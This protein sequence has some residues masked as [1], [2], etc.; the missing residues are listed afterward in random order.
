MNRAALFATIFAVLWLITSAVLLAG[1]LDPP[2]G[3]VAPAYKTLSEVEP[4]I[5]INSTNTPGD[6]DSLFKITQPGSYYFIGNITGVAGKYG[7]EIAV[8]GVSLDLNGFDLVGAAAMGAFDGVTVSID[9]L[10]GLTVRN[11]TVRGWDDAGVD[12]GFVSYG[13]LVKDVRVGDNAGMGINGGVVCTIQ[14]CTAAFNWLSGIRANNGSTIARCSLY[15][16]AG[17]GIQVNNGC[18][19]S[20]CSIYLS[21]LDG[22]LAGIGCRITDTSAFTNLGDG[23]QFG[24]GTSV[25]GCTVVNNDGNGVN[26]GNHCIISN[27][28]ADFNDL[29]GIIVGN[30]CTVSDSSSSKSGFNGIYCAGNDNRISRNA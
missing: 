27:I 20:T 30:G 12:L 4:R 19:I 28:T 24:E 15:L 25:S 9:Q 16:N 22:I 11:G 18:T 7:I 8:S 1:P 13:C 21:S 14:D 10:R 17:N 6:N 29:N 2:A 3:P 26:A 5:A 23:I